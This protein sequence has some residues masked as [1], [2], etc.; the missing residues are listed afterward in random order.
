[1]KNSNIGFS[2]Q[3]YCPWIVFQFW[4]STPILEIKFRLNNPNWIE[5]QDHRLWLRDSLLTVEDI[6]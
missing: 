4:C 1:M 3:P 6:F 2:W 5:Y